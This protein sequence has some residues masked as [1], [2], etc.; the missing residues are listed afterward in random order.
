[1]SP[2]PWN[3]RFL[4]STRGHILL[5]LRREGR[6]VD[7]LAQALALTDNAVRAHLATLER[8][9]LVRQHGARRGSGKPSFLYELTPEADYLFPK[10]YGQVLNE[11]LGILDERM[12]TEALEA[13][14]RAVGQRISAR[15]NMPEGDRRTRV[16]AAIDVLNELGGMAELEEQEDAYCIRGYSCPLAAL[17]PGHPAICHLAESL[18]AEL[19]GAPVREECEQG[20]QARCRFMIAT[21]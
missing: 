21:K 3:Q 12:G 9:G 18:L 20:E 7:E 13:M 19:I 2:I 11:L 14:L 5:M 1:M 6:T 15:W 4:G 16:Q 10:P 8:D 17:V